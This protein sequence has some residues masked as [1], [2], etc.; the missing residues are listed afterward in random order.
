VIVVDASVLVDAL[1]LG[2][3]NGAKARALLTEDLAWAAPENLTVEAFS[4]VRGLAAGGKITVAQAELALRDLT[5]LGVDSVPVS[6]LIDV[7]WDIRH[8]MTGYAA[9]YVAL[10][11]RRG[12]TLVTADLRLA[13]AASSWCRVQTPG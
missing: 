11:R 7:M 9:A 3:A 1:V 13:A 5:A 6:E 4:A 10:A 8:G 12:L 2:G